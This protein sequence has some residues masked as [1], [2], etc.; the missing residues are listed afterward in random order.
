MVDTDKIGDIGDRIEIILQGRPPLH[1]RL[2]VERAP[3]RDADHSASLGA[4]PDLLVG[5]IAGAVDE[6]ARVRMRKDGGL[7]A[8][9]ENIKARC[10][11]D[12]R[13]IDE[14]AEPVALRDPFL[15]H[16]A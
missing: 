6:G 13:Q 15:S 8:S 10:R 2:E 4:A 7:L 16:T 9:G 12:M 11:S 14:D 1:P 3:V 5:D